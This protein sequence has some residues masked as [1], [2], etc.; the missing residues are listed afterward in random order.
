MAPFAGPILADWSDVA[1]WKRAF[2]DAAATRGLHKYYTVRDYADPVTISPARR[3]EIH[4]AAEIAV[5]PVPHDLSSAAFGDAVLA[6]AHA[7]VAHVTD[8]MTAEAA[9]LQARAIAT[10]VV[11]LLSALSPDLRDELDDSKSPFLLWAEVH[12][13]GFVLMDD[14]RLFGL[15]ENVRFVDN[16]QLPDGLARVEE[17]IQRFVDVIFVPSHGLD[18]RLVAAADRL[19]M[20]LLC[21][22]C[23]PAMANI[24]EAWRADEPV[25]NYASMRRR[26]IE[27]CKSQHLGFATN[28]PP[29]SA[30]DALQAQV[31]DVPPA[32]TAGTLEAQLAAVRLQRITTMTCPLRHK[33]EEEADR[34]SVGPMLPRM[35]R[36]PARAFEHKDEIAAPRMSAR[37]Q[38]GALRAAVPESGGHG[39]STE[40]ESDEVSSFRDAAKT[41][42]PEEIEFLCAALAHTKDS[43]HV[44]YERGRAQGLFVHRSWS[45]IQSKL[46]RMKTTA[47]ATQSA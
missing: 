36:K 5:P 7:I 26:L 11:F 19:K 10:A 38:A 4:A 40:S 9:S 33:A 14:C 41:Y 45:S 34:K 18:A 37:L 43:D 44:I 42:E 24:F 8:A 1:A 28:D 27:Q 39:S 35:V 31:V 13:K 3:I 25:W 21:N 17:H 22:A 29:T 20:A 32:T 2:L 16:D 12:A 15:L 23:P 46:C 47:S 30:V 6:R